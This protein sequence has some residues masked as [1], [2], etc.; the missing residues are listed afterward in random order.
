MLKKCAVPELYF[1]GNSFCFPVLPSHF[2][3][4][5]LVQNLHRLLFP[6]AAV[7]AK[8]AHTE[9]SFNSPSARMFLYAYSIPHSIILFIV[10]YNT[11]AIFSIP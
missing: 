2:I 8:F 1:C 6:S 3:P 10:I 7:C 11:F 9:F 4:L 5:E